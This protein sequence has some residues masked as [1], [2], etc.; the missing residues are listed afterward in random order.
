MKSCG[1][2]LLIAA[3]CVLTAPQAEARL[4]GMPMVAGRA[5][6][7]AAAS[8]LAA[9]APK[10]AIRAANGRSGRRGRGG[11]SQT[12]TGPPGFSTPTIPANAPASAGRSREAGRSRSTLATPWS[13][14]TARGRFRPAPPADTG[15]R[16]WP[17]PSMSAAIR[18]GM[19]VR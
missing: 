14:A 16:P 19:P 7:R 4:D 3:S 12:R 11:L 5:P 8:T 18:A 6:Q 15:H 13:P 10:G 17:T 1:P 9:A 2:V